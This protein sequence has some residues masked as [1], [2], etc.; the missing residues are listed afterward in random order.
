VSSLGAGLHFYE[1]GKLQNIRTL[2]ECATEMM[3][4]SPPP[5]V[6]L[7]YRTQ[8]LGNKHTQQKHSFNKQTKAPTTLQALEL[9]AEPFLDLLLLPPASG[10]TFDVGDVGN[11]KREKIQDGRREVMEPLSDLSS[12]SSSLLLLAVSQRQSSGSSLGLREAPLLRT[13]GEGGGGQSW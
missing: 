2:P 10:V 8:S 5:P 4:P 7:A 6:D 1:K 9:D 11:E 13:C 12:R 3:S